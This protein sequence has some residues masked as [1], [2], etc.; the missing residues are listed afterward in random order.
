MTDPQAAP[1]AAPAPGASMQMP[2]FLASLGRAEL[3]MAAG[4][5]LIVIT[6]LLFTV[7]SGYYV[8]DLPFAAAAVAVVAILMHRR[9]PAGLA[10]NY[11]WLLLGLAALVVVIAIRS[12]L[13]DLVYIVTPPAGLGAGRLIGMLGLYV[14]AALMGFGAWQLWGRKA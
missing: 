6:G 4:A 7:V 11:N 13:G 14:G 1:P 8:T 2:G 5:A 12:L 10:A 9:M 3:F